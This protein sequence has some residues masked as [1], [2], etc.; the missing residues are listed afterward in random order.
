MPSRTG[1]FLF[2]LL[3][4]ATAAGAATENPQKALLVYGPGGPHHVLQECAD[5]FAA[6][7]GIDVHIIKAMPGELDRR[8]REDGDIYYGGAEYMLEEFVE[9]NPGVIDLSTAELLHPR[10]IGIIV[11]KGNPLAINGIDD[12]TQAG[13][14]LL[15]V[16]L[17]NMRDFHR[18]AEGRQARIHRYEYTGQRGVTAWLSDPELDAWITYR[19]WHFSIE[20]H[21]DFIELPED[22]A[23]RYTP[24]A[25]T[26][27]TPHREEALA[28]IRFLQ[29]DEAR[30]I[31]T[32][33]GW[34]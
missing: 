16:K 20:E 30:R 15:D 19:S 34:D 23:L 11:R 8:L 25:V 3:L 9:D 14:D 22:Q 5:L 7:H 18:D 32:E 2:G 27:R 26:H 12:L 21:S 31:F 1:G 29:T 10:K 28:F 17:E 13:I 6:T 33:H 24:I 4:L